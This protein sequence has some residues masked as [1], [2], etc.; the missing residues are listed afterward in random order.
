MQ[1]KI[2]PRFGGTDTETTLQARAHAQA[3]YYVEVNLCRISK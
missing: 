3:D 1:Q 2:S